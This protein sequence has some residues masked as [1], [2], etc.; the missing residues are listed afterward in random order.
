VPSRTAASSPANGPAVAAWSD[1]T[2]RSWT[3]W[4]VLAMRS[5]NCLDHHQLHDDNRPQCPERM[6][7]GSGALQ[8]YVTSTE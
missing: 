5:A 1:L 2:T 3:G 8:R 4:R 7:A 6:L